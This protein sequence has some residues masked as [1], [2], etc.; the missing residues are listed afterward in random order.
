MTQTEPIR[1]TDD[2]YVLPVTANLMG[3]PTVLNLTLILD[4]ERGATLVDTGV[5]GSL[6]T[7][8]AGLGTLGLGWADVRRVVVTHHDLDHIGAL[9]DVVAAS[10]AE[11]LA[12]DAEAPYVRGDLPGQKTPSAEMLASMP[13]EMAAVFRDPPRAPVTRTL[14]DGEVL[15]VAGGVRVIAT[16]GH[17]VGHLSLFV[18]RG[19]VLITGDALVSAGGQLRPPMERATPDMTEAARSVRKLTGLPVRT[20][21]TYH[22][23]LV[24]DDAPAQLSRVALELGV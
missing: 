22:G 6:G 5:P 7:I 1:V 13:P 24:T 10:G 17:T 15:D 11:V 2:V 21:V 16:P 19:G 9:P 20:M 3:G 4:A 18:E 14:H 8:E 12:L 23:G